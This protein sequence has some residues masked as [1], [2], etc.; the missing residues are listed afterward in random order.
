VQPEKNREW[1]APL[2]QSLEGSGPTSLRRESPIAAVFGPV[3]HPATHGGTS[4]GVLLMPRSAES[5]FPTSWALRC[6]CFKITEG[7]KKNSSRTEVSIWDLTPA[8]ESLAERCPPGWDARARRLEAVPKGLSPH[9]SPARGWKSHF[10]P[11]LRAGSFPSPR[12]VVRAFSSRMTPAFIFY[13]SREDTKFT[14]C[15]CASELL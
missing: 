15:L 6:R 13:K 12:P 2:R 4:P 7:G 10:P 5:A 9:R 8:G 14:A 3:P 11:R 1:T